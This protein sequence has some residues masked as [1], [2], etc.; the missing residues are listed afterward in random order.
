MQALRLVAG[1]KSR[2]V[3]LFKPI[4]Q[5]HSKAQVQNDSS[6]IGSDY[7]VRSPLP[8]IEIPKEDIYTMVSRNFSKFGTKIGM[9]DGISG[10][11][12]SFNEL[13]ECT[14]KFSSS[15]QRRGFGRGDVMCVVS[16]NCPEYAVIFL[17]VL[18]AGGVVSTCNPTYTVDELAYQFKNSGAKIVTTIPDILSTV[19]AAAAKANVESIIILDSNDPQNSTG[20][21]IS[22]QSLVKDSGPLCIPVPSEPDDVAVLPYS[23]GTTGLP[24]GVMLTNCNVNSNLLQMINPELFTYLEKPSTC[25]MGILPFFHIYG[26]VV[27]LLSSLYGGA[28]I[29]SLPK[30]EPD[31]FLSSIEKHRIDTAHIVPPLILFFAKHPLVDKYDLSSLCEI[32]TGAAPLGGEMVNAVIDRTKCDLIR[33]GYG[34]TETSPVTHMMPRSLET[35]FPSSVGHCIRSVKVKIVDPETKE[36]LPPNLDGE[37]W[38]YGPNIMKGYLNNPEATHDSLVEN[39][40][41]RSGDLGKCNF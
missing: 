22:Y 17:G 10:R 14:C 16:P 2:P 1:F 25:L 23:S 8:D 41:F 37:L 7:V 5:F 19:Q 31:S 6:I 32:M 15:L 3:N 4:S 26:M 24:K 36:A 40:W 21:L 27:V 29:V 30:F 12:Y 39:G 34:L 20:N 38:L 35:E 18:R 13:D 11:E 28:K 9:V 33:Q